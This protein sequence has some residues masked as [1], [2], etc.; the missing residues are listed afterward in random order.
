[1]GWRPGE[2]F[3]SVLKVTGGTFKSGEVNGTG[4]VVSGNDFLLLKAAL[5][6]RERREVV[7]M[8]RC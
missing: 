1:M 4:E 8:A 6:V 2:V 7:I 3:L 5:R